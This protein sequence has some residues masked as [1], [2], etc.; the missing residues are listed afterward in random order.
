MRVQRVMMPGSE[1]DS[2]T[3]LGDDQIWVEPVERFLG[4]LAS[5]EKSPNTVKAYA[6]GLK[7]WF[8]CPR[9]AGE[10]QLCVSSGSDPASSGYRGQGRSLPR[11]RWRADAA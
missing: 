1:A 5:V 6:H 9:S 7:D 4:Y 2:W 11:R 10:T 8:T 3:L